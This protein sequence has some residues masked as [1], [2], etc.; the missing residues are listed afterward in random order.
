MPT[1]IGLHPFSECRK[2]VEEF[3]PLSVQENIQY[4][5]L[6]FVDVPLNEVCSFFTENLGTGETNIAEPCDKE[7]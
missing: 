5:P 6:I 1:V 2:E 7:Q 4:E 3:V